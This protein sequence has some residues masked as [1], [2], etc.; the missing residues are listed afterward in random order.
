M[1]P[2]YLRIPTREEGVGRIG[3]LFI[4]AHED[5]SWYVSDKEGD[6]HRVVGEG[7]DPHKLLPCIV[8]DMSI[9]IKAQRDLHK[10]NM[11]VLERAPEQRNGFS[12]RHGKSWKSR[13]RVHEYAMLHK[14]EAAHDR[15]LAYVSAAVR[16]HGWPAEAWT[17]DLSPG[18]SDQYTHYSEQP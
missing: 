16:D 12:S 17:S 6:K 5:G 13:E 14:A 15:L 2:F 1:T 10:H 8:A 11:G 9:W 18:S 3:Y 4:K 7:T